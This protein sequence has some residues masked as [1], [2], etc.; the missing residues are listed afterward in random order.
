MTLATRTAAVGLLALGAALAGCSSQDAART[1]S[2]A[3]CPP[4][5][6]FDQVQETYFGVGQFIPP[7]EPPPGWIPPRPMDVPQCSLLVVRTERFGLSWDRPGALQQVG[8]RAG[9][10]VAFYVVGE[11]GP[12]QLLLD[13][14]QG[15]IP[16][17]TGNVIITSA[18]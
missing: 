6:G 15:R 8:T 3:T 12:L 16:P 4:F 2:G 1:A 13:W 5:P 17:Q 10:D 18:E 14:G 9:E 7:G 11:P